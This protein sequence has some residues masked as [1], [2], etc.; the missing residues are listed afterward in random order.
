M[1]IKGILGR[2]GEIQKLRVSY[3]ELLL[4]ASKVLVENEPA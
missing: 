4:F 2:N 3:N 1:D